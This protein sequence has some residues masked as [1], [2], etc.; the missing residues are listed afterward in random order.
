MV[1]KLG[2]DT[3]P[4]FLRSR[5]QDF[6][7][8]GLIILSLI[9][10]GVIAIHYWIISLIAFVVLTFIAYEIYNED[11]KFHHQL[12]DYITTLSHRVKKVGDE[13]LMEMPI[14]IILYDETLH[15]EWMNPYMANMVSD[16]SLLSRPLDDISDRLV[17]LI[18]DEK[19]E[20]IIKL[21]DRKY[22]II[23]RKEER[24]I[25]FFDVTELVEIEQLYQEDQTVF[26]IVYLD[27][28]DELTQ[29]MDDQIKSSINSKVTSIIKK[30]GTDFGIY[31]KRT[32]S[33]RFLAILNKKI[34]SDLEKNRFSLLDEVREATTKENIPLTL[35]V[36][37]GV[38]GQSLLDIGQL[39]QSS[40]DLAL[41]RGGDQVAI[42]QP[43]GK[44]KFYGGKSNPIEKRTRVRARVIS[45]A[46]RELILESDQVI[47]MGHSNPDMDAIGS[48]IGIMKIAEA[49]NKVAHIIIEHE[50]YGPGVIRLV[51][52]VKKDATLWSKFISDEEAL[53]RVTN[54]TL[55][56][57]VDTH[58]PSLMMESRLLN[59]TE[60]IVV[61]DHHRR[62]EEFIEDPVLV[63]MEPYASSTAEL[64]TELLE[65]QPKNLKL[66]VLEATALL[67]GITV[68]TKNFTFRTGARTFDAASYLRGHGADTILVQ[69]LLREDL[70]QFN[71]RAKL[72]QRASIYR[73]N[74]AVAVADEEDRYDQV[75]I[76]QA[77]DTL[78]SMNGV[79]A[80]F[81]ISLR[82]DGLIGISARSLGEIN[83]QLIMEGI[84]GGGHLTN[85]ATQIDNMSLTEAEQKLKELIDQYLEGGRVE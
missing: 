76:A 1:G 68:D 36:G 2:A 37:I 11:R 75:M 32:S 39:A 73:D 43:N 64:I 69:K 54:N 38:D 26:G 67:A 85:A 79:V 81:V 44:V 51:E 12:E 63:Y 46:L 48:C 78:L 74:I 53:E 3:M 56:V 77:A 61:M 35:S 16:D 72:I 4:N 7:I 5:K 30:W 13:A 28:Y 60:R 47:V 22:R 9:F 15:I 42:K 14:G 20:E 10:L 62:G 45:H 40:L 71:Q 82:E 25:Y 24:L 27:N 58:K 17:H 59:R 21:K 83:V 55:L 57:V 66:N 80:S 33:E 8:S 18:T 70:K 49:N 65:Y 29:G 84:H 34:L 19:D 41:G 31:L 50:H 52:E 6:Y 23:V